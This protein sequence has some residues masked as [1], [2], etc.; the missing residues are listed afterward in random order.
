MVGFVVVPELD[1][2]AEGEVVGGEFADEFGFFVNAE[3][4]EEE[5]I[6]VEVY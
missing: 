2:L 1:A 6:E 5:F 3:G 4:S